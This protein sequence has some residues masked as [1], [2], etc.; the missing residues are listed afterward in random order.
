MKLTD[1]LE[2]VFDGHQRITR[3]KWANSTIY[4]GLEESKLCIKGVDSDG[5]WHPWCISE[6][7]YFSDDWEI[8][9]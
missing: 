1:A 4:C 2:D 3:R 5:Q 9:E 8:V 6:E 7:D